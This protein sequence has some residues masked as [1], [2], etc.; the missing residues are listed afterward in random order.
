M[1]PF[2]LRQASKA[3]TDEAFAWELFESF[4]WPNGPRCPRC[5]EYGGAYLAPRGGVRVTR[6]GKVSHRKVYKCKACRHQFTALVG[7]VFED[8]KI[9]VGKWIM[10]VYLMASA[11]NGVSA[12]ELHRDLGITYKIGLVHVPP[13]AP[14]N[15]SVPR[16]RQ[17]EWWRR[18]V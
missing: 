13:P 12:H 8:S 15:V 3:L 7:T 5:H 14:C 6:T 4:R 9:P 10:A 2:T 18:G 11:K 17:V 16:R 1:E